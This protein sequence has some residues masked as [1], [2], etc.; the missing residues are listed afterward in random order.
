MRKH[1][2][3]HFK[4]IEGGVE[5]TDIV[6]Y[7]LPFGILGNLANSLFVKKQGVPNAFY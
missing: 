2:K 1:K 5:M 7:V 4:K 6:N 3:H